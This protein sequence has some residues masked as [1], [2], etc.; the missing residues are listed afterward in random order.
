MESIREVA[1]DLGH[2]PSINEYDS[3]D[4]SPSGRYIS[5]NFGWNDIK[6]EI[7]LEVSGG[8]SYT[9]EE[10]IESVLDAADNVDGHLTK[11]KYYD[12]GYNPTEKALRKRFGSWGKVKEAAKGVAELE[13]Q[14]RGFGDVSSDDI[15]S[16]MEEVEKEVGREPSFEEYKENGGYPMSKIR[17]FFG[18]WGN[19]KESAGMDRRRTGEDHPS[20]VEGFSLQCEWCDSEYEVCPSKKDTS[21]FCSIECQSNWKSESWVR[22]NNPLWAGGTRDRIPYRCIRRQIEDDTWWSIRNKIVERDNN[23]CRMCGEEH[24]SLHVHHLVPLLSGGR[25]TDELLMSL[26]PGCHNSVE[27][28]TEDFTEDLFRDWTDGEMPEGRK[29]WTPDDE[30]DTIP[31]TAC[32]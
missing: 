12:G 23:E 6:D 8:M 3:F 18:T 25:N 21:R 17:Q 30:P 27:T 24:D 22:E 10:C 19:A 14:K 28:Y 1:N 29:R 2:S 16:S 32:L 11:Q 5:N 7:G 15:I 9:R 13:L 26:C 20:W 31:I 4:A